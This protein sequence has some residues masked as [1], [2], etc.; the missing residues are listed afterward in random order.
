MTNPDIRIKN[1]TY[2]E[3]LAYLQ[4]KANSDPQAKCLVEQLKICA[5]PYYQLP[6]GAYVLDGNNHGKYKIN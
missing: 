2:S 5:K 6:S 3:L 4:E 1:K